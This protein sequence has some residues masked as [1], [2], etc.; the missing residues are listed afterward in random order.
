MKDRFKIFLMF[1]LMGFMAG[2]IAKAT[3][4]NIIPWLA[5][6]FPTIG[7]DWMLSGVAGA[8]LT[9]GLVMAWAYISGSGSSEK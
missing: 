2:I 5:A 4:Q 7:L 9:V 3:Y 6:N 1:G 8:M